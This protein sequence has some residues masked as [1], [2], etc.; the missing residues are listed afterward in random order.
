MFWCCF[1]QSL[2]NGT[3]YFP[4][5]RAEDYRE[6]VHS[7]IYRCRASNIAGTILSREVHVQAG[8]NDDLITTSNKTINFVAY[9]KPILSPPGKN[10]VLCTCFAFHCFYGCCVGFV[11]SVS[12]LLKLKP[13]RT[14]IFNYCFSML[15]NMSKLNCCRIRRFYASP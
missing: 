7:T 2:G 8:K 10:P 13:Q 14:D 1:R 15:M 4:P 9:F 6:D 3:L 12:G 5:F 11:S